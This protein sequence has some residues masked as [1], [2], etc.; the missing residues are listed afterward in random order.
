MGEYQVSAEV[1]REGARIH[2]GPECRGKPFWKA[3]GQDPVKWRV[4]TLRDPEILPW[5][6]PKAFKKTWMNLESIILGEVRHR[7]RNIVWYGLYVES[8]KKNDKMNLFTR[9]KQIHRLKS[10]TYSWGKERREGQ[11]GSLGLTHTLHTAI[12][13]TDNR[14]GPLLNII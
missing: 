2:C 9:Q 8:K 14:Q 10:W 7:K 3:S 12:F 11:L 5:N 4:C 6:I 13:K 1:E